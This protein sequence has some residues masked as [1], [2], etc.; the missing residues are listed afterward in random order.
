ML[1]FLLTSLLLLSNVQV[2]PLAQETAPFTPATILAG[3]RSGKDLARARQELLT[4]GPRVLPQLFRL[5]AEDRLE[6]GAGAAPLSPLQRT[7]LLAALAELPHADLSAHLSQLARSG[8][9]AERRAGLELLARVGATSDL[10]QVLDLAGALPDAGQ[11]PLLRR[12]L[13]AIS[14]RDDS[15][16][17]AV[18]GFYSRAQPAAQS[19]IA[20]TLAG[21]DADSAADLFSN[22]LGSAGAEADAYL[23]LL[24]GERNRWPRNKEGLLAERTRAYLNHSDPRLAVLACGAVEQ[25][26]DDEA[27]PELIALLDH[28]RAG[29]QQRAHGSLV[30]L[31]GLELGP[32]AGPWLAWLDESLTWWDERSVAC[33]DALQDGSASEAAAAVHE[34]GSQRL[35]LSRVVQLLL[36]ALERPETDVVLLAVRALGA[37]GE[38]AARAALVELLPQAEP[39]IVE[40]VRSTLTRF[41]RDVIRRDGPRPAA[42]RP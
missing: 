38:T 37:T 10:K 25:L 24:I 15:A 2:Q 8:S 31:T 26:R 32:V 1:P 41:D 23:L 12:V 5:W 30:R 3:V 11:V 18:A 35:F 33:A 13:G 4:L 29:V 39:R 36:P 16:L 21:S 42:P 9:L 40:Q 6:E 22:L 27:V 19:A 7:T 28:A 17:R 34:I 14:S 20:E